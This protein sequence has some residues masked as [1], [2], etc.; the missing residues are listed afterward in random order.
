VKEWVVK[1][2]P[3][4]FDEVVGNREVIEACKHYISDPDS[5]PH[6]LFYG[7]RGTGKNTI[8]ELLVKG[9]LG[10]H[11]R[12]A[13]KEMNA[14]DDRGI[15]VIRHRVIRYMRETGLGIFN[16]CPFKILHLDE[17]DAITP[18]AQQALKR[19][20]EKYK[21]NCRV[22]LSCNDVNK[23]IPEIRDR[24]A[25]FKFSPLPKEDVIARLNY[26]L[27]AEGINKD[28]DLE[29]IYRLSGGSMRKA[30]TLL[31]QEAMITS[32]EEDELEKI[33]KQYVNR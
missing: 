33:I 23:I 20:L 2:A 5:M 7:L 3:K 4:S 18:D 11:W 10:E 27:Q 6:L 17:A 25:E 13:F 16:G 31:Q 29:K 9:I 24:C 22:I 12:S 32:E 26:I 15:D 19:P 21:H 8:V 28:I 1:Y 30:I 14:S